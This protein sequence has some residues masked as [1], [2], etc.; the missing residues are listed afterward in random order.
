MALMMKVK[1]KKYNKRKKSQVKGSSVTSAHMRT[2]RHWENAEN[3][4]RDLK[5][6]KS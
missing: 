1:V 5:K 3:A 4:M 2:M 6:G